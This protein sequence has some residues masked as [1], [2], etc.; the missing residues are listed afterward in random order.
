MVKLIAKQTTIVLTAMCFLA[1][2]GWLHFHDDRLSDGFNK[3]HNA[4]GE[5]LTRNQST[6]NFYKMPEGIKKQ[7]SE[8]V[9]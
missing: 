7:I 9:E 1:I 6:E 8:V 4:L 5:S 2:W 3:S